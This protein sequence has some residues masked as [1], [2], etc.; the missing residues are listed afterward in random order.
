MNGERPSLLTHTAMMESVSLREQMKS[1]RSLSS[2]TRKSGGHIAFAKIE[3]KW[4][5]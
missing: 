4:E 2:L 3:L 5:I 1:W